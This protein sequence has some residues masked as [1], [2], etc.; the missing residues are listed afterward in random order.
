MVRQNIPSPKKYQ[1]VLLN[2]NKTPTE[3]VVQI[4]QN[5]FHKTSHES[6]QIMMSIHLKGTGIVGAYTYEIA[7][8]R[9]NNVLKQ[10]RKSQHPLQCELEVANVI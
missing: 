1:V 6:A 9:L 3:F 8:T 5:I 2:D 4:L 7:E 10:A